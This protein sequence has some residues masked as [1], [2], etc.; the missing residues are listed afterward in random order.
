MPRAR[1]HRTHPDVVKRLKRAVGQLHGICGMI[2]AKR[3]CLQVAQQLQAAANAVHEA[4]KT[5][6]HGHLNR[7]LDTAVGSDARKARAQLI[8]FKAISKYV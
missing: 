5:F 2:E 4:K 1:I 6:I 7:C 3:P 8:E